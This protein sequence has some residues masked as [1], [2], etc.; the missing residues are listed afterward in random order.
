MIPIVTHITKT[1]ALL[2]VLLLPV[3]GSMAANCCCH[4]GIIQ[5]SPERSADLFASRCSKLGASCCGQQSSDPC[6][7]HSSGADSDSQPC[8]CPSGCRCTTSPD[9]I[10]YSANS[11]SE[12]DLTAG[13]APCASARAFQN[14]PQCLLTSADVC[15]TASGSALCVRLCRFQ[16]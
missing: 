5:S 9:A 11:S 14:G 6:C 1:L 16:L 10:A 2:A 12:L 3:Q 7:C 8:R 13:I 15:S 4:R